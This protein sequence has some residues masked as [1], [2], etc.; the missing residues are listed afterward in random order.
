[1]SNTE[2]SPLL[3]FKML[4]DVT[5]LHCLLLVMSEK[6]LCVCELEFA[7]TEEQPKI[8]RHLRLLRQNQL[9]I[10]ERQGR[11][12]YYL[13]NNEL[14]DWVNHILLLTLQNNQENM[15][16]LKANLTKMADRPKGCCG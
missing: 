5:R 15:T 7:L 8:S 4:A 16:V 14:P 10:T 6:R 9:L 1:M 13:V 3:L 12:I 11:W 2:I